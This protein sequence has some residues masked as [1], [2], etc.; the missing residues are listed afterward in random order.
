[1]IKDEEDAA[2]NDPDYS[3]HEE[4]LDDGNG[5]TSTSATVEEKSTHDSP[6][7]ITFPK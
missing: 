4:V 5:D 1:M 3:P 7:V 2:C 6:P